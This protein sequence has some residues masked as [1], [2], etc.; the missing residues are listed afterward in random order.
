[1][2]I[3]REKKSNTNLWTHFSYNLKKKT[4]YNNN[5]GNIQNIIF[6]LNIKSDKFCFVRA[7]FC[8]VFILGRILFELLIN[9][10][11]CSKGAKSS[12]LRI[13]LIY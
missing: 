7:F 11:Q 10:V 8:I 13:G 9:I 3:G 1:M 5:F 12:M 6:R 4:R 2:Y